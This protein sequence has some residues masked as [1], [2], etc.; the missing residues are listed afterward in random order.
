MNQHPHCVGG[1]EG[2]RVDGKTII[3]LAKVQSVPRLSTRIVDGHIF[4]LLGLIS[5]AI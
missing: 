3:M 4:F 2:E 5:V 1:G